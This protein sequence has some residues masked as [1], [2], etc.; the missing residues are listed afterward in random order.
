MIDERMMAMMLEDSLNQKDRLNEAPA[1]SV[2][3]K[4]AAAMVHTKIQ[5]AR[6]WQDHLNSIGPPS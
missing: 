4:R 6:L 5:E 1:A 2:E 3:R